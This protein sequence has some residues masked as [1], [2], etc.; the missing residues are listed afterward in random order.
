MLGCFGAFSVSG[1]ALRACSGWARGGPPTWAPALPAPS[2][3]T[4]GSANRRCAGRGGRA[5]RGS[6]FGAARALREPG[7]EIYNLL[8]GSVQNT[9]IAS[10]VRTQQLPR[11][12]REPRA[13]APA[14]EPPRPQG[15]R[16]ARLAPIRFAAL[17][18]RRLRGRARPGC[19]GAARARFFVDPA[20]SPRRRRGERGA[21]SGRFWARP[22]TNAV[23]V[24]RSSA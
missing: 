23:V 13:R 14:S 22:K 21:F 7:V 1:R 8:L 11:A 16:G 17:S 5:R 9:S 15:V 4:A 24:F 2:A 20:A 6:G 3:P 12:L 19:L 18:C 10:W